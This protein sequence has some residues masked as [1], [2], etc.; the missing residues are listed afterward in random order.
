[1]ACAADDVATPAP[2]LLGEGAYHN[3][4]LHDWA[5]LPAGITYGGTHGC[6]MVDSK[7]R[8]YVNTEGKYAVLVFEA[9]GHFIT[10]WG[11]EF[12]KAAHG[13]CLVKEG[14]H[15]VIWLA[16]FGLHRVIAFSL[17]GDVLQ[18]IPWPEQA[19]AYHSPNDFKPTSVAVTPNGEVYV[20]DGYGLGWVHRFSAAGVLIHSW[21]GAEGKAGIF[22]TPHDVGIDTRTQ[23]ARVVACDRENHRLQLFSLDGPY[24]DVVEGLRRPCKA[25]FHGNVLIVPDL[26]GR[27]TI[28]DP[29][30]HVVVEL[31]DNPDVAKRANDNVPPDQ[32]K[33][34]EF[35][36]PHGA[37]EDS[38]GRGLE[39]DRAGD[40]APEDHLGRTALPHPGPGWSASCALELR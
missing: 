37:N 17:D 1:M 11:E 34:G 38:L 29:A 26:A 5:K 32:W 9:N 20:A 19:T 35:T 36:A 12:T 14:D 28:V 21:N 16:H 2:V 33:D 13:M 31:G 39:H 27:V 40:Q 25:I 7:D 6:V 18:S 15:E 10:G 23:P 22:K 30:Y 24:L 4:W 8:I 3:Q